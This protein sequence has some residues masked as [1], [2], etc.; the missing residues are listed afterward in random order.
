[1]L[2]VSG[3]EVEERR[4]GMLI[5]QMLRDGDGQLTTLEP[6]EVP[7]DGDAQAESPLLEAFVDGFQRALRGRAN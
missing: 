5:F 1:V 3:M 4:A 7:V 6:Y 2:I